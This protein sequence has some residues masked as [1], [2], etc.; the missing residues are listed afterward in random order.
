MALAP[1]HSSRHLPA[2]D[3]LRG[4]AI[5]GVLACHFVR[6]PD[7]MNGTAL[8]FLSQA[9]SLGWLGVD[10]F[11]VLSGFL[12][13][14]IL[15]DSKEHPGYF[16]NFYARRVLRIF[17]L[18]YAYILGLLAL[19]LAHRTLA[20]ANPTTD[21]FVRDVR[22]ALP[23]L[24]NVQMALHNG[25]V[26]TPLNHFWSLCIEEQFYLLW[27]AVVWLTS[28]RQLAAI[29]LAL[30]VAAAALRHGLIE[31]GYTEA[32]FNLM[33]C[34]GDSLATGALLAL[35]V[36]QPAALTSLRQIPRAVLLLPLM[37]IP[38]G[39][40][41]ATGLPGSL[42]LSLAALAFGALLLFAVTSPDGSSAARFFT[43]GFLRTFGKYS[44]A[45]Y[46][47]NQMVA[48]FPGNVKVHEKL[49]ALTSSPSIA[50]VL[51]AAGGVG[52]SFLL[53]W[54]SWHLMEK[55]FLRLKSRFA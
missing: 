36:R 38:P 14:G 18:Y 54:A 53:A 6:V 32:A 48:F 20:G 47:F 23:Y 7:G 52:I 17:P 25:N 24:T 3:G 40:I 55:H 12:I 44:Y 35:A 16:R 30:I 46:V 19:V 9:A 22:W 39:V 1:Y 42:H 11:F 29:S 31:A 26:S 8:G 2:L 28:R 15:V 43:S 41:Q 34:R 50:L 21:Q 37:F 51:F 49:V 4:L 5:I 10:L 27:P 33:P 13:T 45:L